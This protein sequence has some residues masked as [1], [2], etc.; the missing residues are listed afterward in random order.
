MICISMAQPNR[1]ASRVVFL[2]V[3]LAAI[4]L[5]CSQLHAQSRSKRLILKDGSY[6]P[7]VRWEVKGDRVRYF[8][9]ERYEW[10]DLPM[11]LVD[12]PAT[13]K[14][15]KNLEAGIAEEEKRTAAEDEAE[16]KA[17]ET[18]SPTV[19]PGLKLPDTGGVYLLDIYQN[20]PELIELVQSGGE[21]HKNMGK[22]ILRAAINPIA[23]SSKQTIEIKG[24]RGRVQA[25]AMQPVIYVDIS[26]G[27]AGNDATSDADKEDTASDAS[28]DANKKDANKNAKKDANMPKAPALERRFRIV[29]LEKK[30]D[31]RVIGNL[32]IM[33]YGKMSQQENWVP[34][35]V[36]P[37]SS[38]WVKVTPTVPLKPGEYAVAEMLG[39]KEMNLFV[40]DFGVDPS[41]PQ[42]PSA[43]T[44]V[45][46]KTTPMGTEETPILQPRPR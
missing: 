9:A 25:H 40:W 34:V 43:W 42:N 21:I 5:P 24:A 11:S 1:L 26:E 39:E 41:A 13:E 23:L 18:R 30:K 4:V 37:V 20:K 29:R 44:P 38:E 32:K 28:K 16:R 35:Q 27:D 31:T 15:E 19:A 7:A 10:E 3:V 6:Q 46:P 12:W 8:S 17:E 14:Y 22:N 36:E 45:Q 33:F 2:V